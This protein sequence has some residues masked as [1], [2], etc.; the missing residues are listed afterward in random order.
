MLLLKILLRQ[1]YSLSCFTTTLLIALTTQ[2]SLAFSITPPQYGKTE[3]SYTLAN[4]TRGTT[5]LSPTTLTSITRGGIIGFLG[6][7]RRDF[8][9]WTFNS[10]P[11]DLAG[12]FEVETYNAVGTALYVDGESSEFVGA[13]LILNY[14]PGIGD[15]TLSSV[16][17]IQRVYTNHRYTPPPN[18]IDEHG[19]YGDIIDIRPGNVANP[20]YDAPGT[21]GLSLAPGYFSDSPARPD[22]DKNHSWL[23]QLYLVELTGSEQVTI[24]NG[25]QWGWENKVEPVPEPITIFGSGMGLGLG[26]LFKK[27]VQRNRKKEKAS[28]S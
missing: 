9:T 12:R 24:Y 25:V 27:N 15:P 22:P 20:F 21:D 10:A 18:N 4:Q 5:R 3:E 16:H 17:W 13:N 23:A 14:V 8:P 7:L 6:T 2:S 19:N 28:K 1:R 11:N 26:V